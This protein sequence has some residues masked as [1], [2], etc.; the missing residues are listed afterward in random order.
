[1]SG[2]VK[3]KGDGPLSSK[4]R[5]WPDQ[6]SPDLGGATPEVR[7]RSAPSTKT[8]RGVPPGAPWEAFIAV[9]ALPPIVLLADTCSQCRSAK[10]VARTAEA[11]R[12]DRRLQVRQWL[13]AVEAPDEATAIDPPQRRNHRCRPQR[14]VAASPPKRCGAS[15]SV[16]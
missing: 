6:A 13:R 2:N 9:A 14:Q 12:L 3:K 1:M 11:A 10:Q 5:V 15:I 8:L 4:S 7:P 16:K